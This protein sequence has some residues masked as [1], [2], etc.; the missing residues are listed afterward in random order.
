MQY[1]IG[2]TPQLRAGRNLRSWQKIQAHLANTG[3]ADLDWLSQFCA[4]HDHS[5]GGSGF[6]QY[7]IRHEWL[8]PLASPPQM[9][10]SQVVDEHQAHSPAKMTNI[11]RDSGIYIAI[12]HTDQYM[13]VTRDPR[14][15]ATCARVN[16][17]NVKVGKARSFK[18]RESN[19]WKDFDRHNVEFIPIAR[20]DDIKRAETA[21]L[22]RLDAY[23]LLSPKN[24]K[25]DWLVGIHPGQVVETAY[26]VLDRGGFVYQILE[27][28]F[29]PFVSPNTE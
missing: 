5:T 7:C 17:Q 1:R 6:V 26:A 22:Q 24:S 13:P 10:L 12:L 3:S 15:V 23:R 2:K 9:Q 25:M 11:S 8:V 21:I 18:V 16:N 4:D 29:C 19:Y 27:N 28:R 14:Y 20:L